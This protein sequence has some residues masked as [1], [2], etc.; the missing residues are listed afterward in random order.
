MLFGLD[1]VVIV[2]SFLCRLLS[3][4]LYVRIEA[5]HPHPLAVEPLGIAAPAPPY[6]SFG[7]PD[8]PPL[9][10]TAHVRHVSNASCCCHSPS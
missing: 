4:V 3:L 7:V 10:L 9:A 5:I 1:A 6:Q 8:T 2:C